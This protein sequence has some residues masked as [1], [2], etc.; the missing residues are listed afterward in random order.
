MQLHRHNKACEILKEIDKNPENYFIIHYSCESFYDKED[1]HSPRITSIAVYR[2]YDAQTDSFSI[3]RSAEKEGVLFDEIESNYDLLEKKML[4]DYFEF[5]RTHMNMKWIHWNMRDSNYGF[6]AIEF[7]YQVLKGEPIVIED[8]KKI[9]LARLLIDKYGARYI[10]DP[11]MQSLMQFNN[12]SE[13]DFLSGKDEAI[14]FE[15]KDYIK[16]HLSTLRKVNVFY[17]IINRDLQ[18]TLKIKSN[19]KDIYGVSLQGIFDYCQSKWWF[20]VITIIVSA[21]A[22][23]VI[24]RII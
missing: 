18:K 10:E 11:K 19:W 24:G 4:D 20:W 23:V 17:T 9:D 5:V 7:R 8:S 12:I 2:Y 16:L 15:N 22:G 1:G 14:A 6:K 3:H 21:I 13:K